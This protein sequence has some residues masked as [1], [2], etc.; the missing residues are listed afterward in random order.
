MEGSL[1]RRVLIAD[2]DPE[3]IRILARAIGQLHNTATIRSFPSGRSLVHAVLQVDP[4]SVSRPDLIVV[5]MAMP[6]LTG[7][8]VLATLKEAGLTSRITCV[9]Y[10]SCAD[11]KQIERCFE[12]GAVDFIPKTLGFSDLVTRLNVCANR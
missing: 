9:V 6:G 11:Q 2:D 4:N 8:E 5:D 3:D 1:L 10:S 7:E 12:H